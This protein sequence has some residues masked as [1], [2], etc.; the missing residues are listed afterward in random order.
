M[1]APRHLHLDSPIAKEAERAEAA[2]RREIARRLYESALYLLREPEEATQ[3]STLLRR[4]G[5]LY[6]DD[7]DFDAGMECLDAAITIAECLGDA[8][9]LAYSRNMMAIGH[10][11]RG[12]VDAA[13]QLWRQTLADAAAA[14][15][16]K[17][18]AMVQQNLGILASMRGDLLTALEQLGASL[19]AYR[20]L[21]ADEFLASLLNNI[22]L[23]HANMKNWDEAEANYIEALAHCATSGDVATSLM[24][25]A[26][27]AQ[28]RIA[29]RDLDEA[30]RICQRL[31]RRAAAVNDNRAA[32][33]AQRHAG[34]V[35]REQRRFD[36][37]DRYLDLAFTG[38][39]ERG[40]LLLAAEAAREQAELFTM[41]GRNRDTLQALAAS[42]RIFRQLRARRD[43]ADVSRRM[44]A[45]ESRFLDLMRD[46]ASSIDS[47]DSYT[48]GHCERVS[49]YACVLA[50]NM[51][52]DETR[53]FWF[54]I[55]A[56]LHDVGK[57]AVPSE[58]LNKPGKLTAEERIIIEG[59]A[60]A[61]ADLLRDIEFPWDILP[62]VRSHHERWDG[63]GYP[64]RLA[65][66]DI[67]L[68]ARILCVADVFDALTSDRPY[69]AAL[70][71]EEALEVMRCDEGGFDPEILAR[72]ARLVPLFPATLFSRERPPVADGKPDTRKLVLVA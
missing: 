29:R 9:A 59:H 2:G 45:L 21:G 56:L 33:E 17:L 18:T 20:A 60:R 42:H 10:C 65:G 41:Q 31:M 54:R 34:V 16:A 49:S 46:W 36:D 48:L 57:I 71:R 13:E 67:P 6:L 39:M 37:A 26:N 72:F 52:F 19:A 11:N 62:I 22:G 35:A 43:L 1:T 38:A 32:A 8:S 64:D 61:G 14:G 55:G 66:E 30:D 69:R 50:E 53:L 44:R 15:D 12:L 5:R 40:D 70:S 63:K 58:I 23:A 24:V 47:K 27:R 4:I 7:G 3:A 28:V 25:E 68:D 51:G